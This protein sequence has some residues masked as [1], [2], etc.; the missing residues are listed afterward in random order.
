MARD[1][2][3]PMRSDGML[4]TLA[5]VAVVVAAF[6]L[7]A[8]QGLWFFDGPMFGPT[9]P[10]RVNLTVAGDLQINFTVDSVRWGRNS[11]PV[12]LVAETLSTKSGNGISAPAGLWNRANVANGGDGVSTNRGLVVENI[13]N[14]PV[15]LSLLSDKDGAAL[16]GIPGGVY[17][18]N[19]VENEVGSCPNPIPSG[20]SA[21]WNSHWANVNTVGPNGLEVCGRL[22]NEAPGQTTNSLMIHTLINVTNAVQ[23]TSYQSVITATA[24]AAVP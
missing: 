22:L 21:P 17:Q 12:G 6:G 19:V 8:A 13:G 23:A 18:W 16:L 2:V 9:S 10:G 20:G 14:T 7:M 3:A 11:A 24:T 1:D 5:V 15:R 4:L